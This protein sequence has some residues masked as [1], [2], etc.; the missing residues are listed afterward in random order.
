MLCIFCTLPR[1]VRVTPKGVTPLTPRRVSALGH[2]LAN[3]LIS[4]SGH[5]DPT[6]SGQAQ[7]TGAR[8]Y[9]CRTPRPYQLGDPDTNKSGR[10]ASR[11]L[12]GGFAVQR[13]AKA[14]FDGA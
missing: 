2:R 9:I 14:E 13:S 7:V 8:L 5:G 4:P 11:L 3:P 1:W 6:P 12:C 10:V